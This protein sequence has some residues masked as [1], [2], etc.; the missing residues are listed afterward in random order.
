[1]TTVQDFLADPIV[2]V[3]LGD[4]EYAASQ[5]DNIRAALENERR[6][7]AGD[8]ENGDGMSTESGGDSGGN[9]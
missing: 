7:I 1:M 6:A 8:P 5:A 3:L 2:Q 9:R 4:P